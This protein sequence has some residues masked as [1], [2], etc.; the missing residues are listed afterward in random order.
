[1][2]TNHPINRATVSFVHTTGNIG[3]RC[4]WFAWST[5]VHQRTNVLF[6]LF[7]LLFVLFVLLFFLFVLLFFLLLFLLLLFRLLLFLLFLLFLLCLFLSSGY[8]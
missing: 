5:F 1:M 4:L 8:F 3:H 6:C 2:G 7:V